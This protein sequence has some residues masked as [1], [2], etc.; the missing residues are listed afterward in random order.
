MFPG[1]EGEERNQRMRKENLPERA[2]IH[3]RE[4]TVILLGSSCLLSQLS[5]LVK[6]NI[7]AHLGF[8]NFV[9]IQLAFEPESSPFQVPKL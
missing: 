2:Q 5:I 8:N 7:L 4:Q 3:Q 1:T 9:W 6:K